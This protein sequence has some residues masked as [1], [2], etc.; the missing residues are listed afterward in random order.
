MNFDLNWFTTIPGILI[1]LG[2]VLLIVAL[3]IFIVTSKNNKKNKDANA[4]ATSADNT[5]APTPLDDVYATPPQTVDA[6]ATTAATPNPAV[7]SVEPNP[8]GVTTDNVVV[9][10]DSGS[11]LNQPVQ[12]IDASVATL[13]QV[14]DAS[15][16]P[17]VEE[18]NVSVQPSVEVSAP[19]GETLDIPVTPVVEDIKVE[20]V[21]NNIANV[22]VQ[23][24]AEPVQNI[25]LAGVSPIPNASPVQATVPD[26][27]P[28]QATAPDVVPTPVV[29]SVPEKAPS[30]YGGVSQ[31]IP[32]INIENDNNH[33]IYGGANPLENTQSIPT[34]QPSVNVA[35]VVDSQQQI[36]GANN[37]IP[38]VPSVSVDA[39]PIPVPVVDNVMPVENASVIPAAP[40]VPV[41][42]PAIPV[43][44][45]APVTSPEQQ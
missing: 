13:P 40:S 18:P 1:T 16:I 25:S 9:N 12:N 11:A 39:Q 20:P 37:A 35:P 38:A 23:A 32:D 3:I 42:I 26:V 31:I 33:Q 4:T 8:V 5:K 45:T 19:V 41:G 43:V 30:I 44:A 29:D 36:A 2:V 14:E 22:Q 17:V 28:V 21:D 34:V 24:S 6:T 27:T 15:S 10:V 7:V